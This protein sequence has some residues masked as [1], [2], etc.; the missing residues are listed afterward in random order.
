MQCFILKKI[1][2]DWTKWFTLFSFAFRVL[3]SWAIVSENMFKKNDWENLW[4]DKIMTVMIKDDNDFKDDKDDNDVKDDKDD[5]D[6][7]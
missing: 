5:N 7:D 1:G 3:R 6:K 4:Q 2:G